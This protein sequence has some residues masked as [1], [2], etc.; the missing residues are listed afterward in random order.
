MAARAWTSFRAAREA[1]G[2]TQESLAKALKTSRNSVARWERGEYL[3]QAWKRRRL[4]E[5]LDVTLEELNDVLRQTNPQQPATATAIVSHSSSNPPPGDSASLT[6][7]AQVAGA[8]PVAEA[9]LVHAAN[10]GPRRAY[11]R[12]GVPVTA[13]RKVSTPLPRRLTWLTVNRVRAATRGVAMSENLYGGGLSCEAAAAQL[14][15]AARLMDV[16][17]DSEVRDAVIEAVGNL[18]SVVAFSAFDIASYDAADDYF[19]FALDCAGKSGSWALRANTLAEMA[20][21][22]TYLKDYDYALELIELAQVRADRLTA[23]ARAML[24]TV[25]ARLLGLM[26]RHREVEGEI[27]RADAFF[28]DRDPA[29]DPPWLCYYDAAEHYGSTGKALIPIARAR[30]EPELVIDRLRAAVDL[31]ADEYPRSRTFSRIRLA[32]ALMTSGQVDA[33]VQA[34]RQ[35][36]VEAGALESARLAGEL[37]GLAEVA[38]ALANR[39]DALDLAHTIGLLQEPEPWDN[40]AHDLRLLDP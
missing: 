33:G 25:R 27:S 2:H 6:V 1:A 14:Q 11:D 13:L 3:P 16:P 22:A 38:G 23:T 34:G 31:H 17:A 26:N 5:A 21:K 10:R 8:E 39:G 19:E 24:A 18:A 40:R 30:R 35:A 4:A 9:D 28:A 29:A 20:R 12:R 15:W 32:S 7:P 36:V 37:G